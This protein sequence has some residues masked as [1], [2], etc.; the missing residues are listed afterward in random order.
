M[1]ERTT[2][3]IALNSYVIQINFQGGSNF[4]MDFFVI[5]YKEK[6]PR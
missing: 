6:N 3:K 4:I 5:A 2:A 1:Q